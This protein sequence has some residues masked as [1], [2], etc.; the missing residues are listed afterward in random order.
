VI[1]WIL[2]STVAAFA[3]IAVE[4]DDLAYSIVCLCGAMIG[5]GVLYY[6]LGA[7][8]VA[9]FHILIYGGTITVLLFAVVNLTE[10]RFRRLRPLPVRLTRLPR[11]TWVEI[12]GIILLVAI[13][14]AVLASLSVYTPAGVGTTPSTEV[15]QQLP[16]WVWEHR[17]IDTMAQ[18]FILFVAM[19]A[20]HIL[21]WSK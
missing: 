2:L 8:Y 20:V 10:E 11:L 13:L 7:P 12:L 16:R 17:L 5:A 21:W 4:L 6:L 1:D 15:I 3:V 19:L 14:G 18:A 9:V